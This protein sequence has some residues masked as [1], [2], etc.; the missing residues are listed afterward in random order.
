MGVGW[1]VVEE[2]NYG[3][4]PSW[5]VRLQV[6]IALNGSGSKIQY[7]LSSLKVGVR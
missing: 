1:S 3:E 6:N 2:R 5:E 4:A 7:Y